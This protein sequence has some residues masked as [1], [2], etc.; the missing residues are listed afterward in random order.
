MATPAI[1]PTVSLDSTTVDHDS[2]TGGA[3]SPLLGEAR[4][5]N[6]NSSEENSTPRAQRMQAQSAPPPG[7]SI[8]VRIHSSSPRGA[9]G[10]NSADTVS[11]DI[12]ASTSLPGIPDS[13]SDTAVPPLRVLKPSRREPSPPPSM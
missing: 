1:G 9:N 11:A 7:D 12:A 4:A 6:N 10:D 8:A 2:R 5:A 3:L 13:S